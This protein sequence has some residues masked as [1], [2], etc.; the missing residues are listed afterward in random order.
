MTTPG[1]ARRYTAA[2]AALGR[3]PVSLM[4]PVNV[5]KTTVYQ[6]AKTGPPAN[7]LAWLEAMASACAAVPVPVVAETRGRKPRH[8]QMPQAIR[9]GSD[10]K[11]TC[12]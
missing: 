11:D 2:L 4:A 3:L 10:G 7:V 12:G 8:P 9:V 6:W 5:G 1:A